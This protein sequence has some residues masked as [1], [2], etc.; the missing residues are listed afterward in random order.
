MEITQIKPKMRI[1]GL[2]SQPVTIVAID[3]IGNSAELI[4][5]RDDGTI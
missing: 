2:E 1:C 3:I 4:Y 5:K